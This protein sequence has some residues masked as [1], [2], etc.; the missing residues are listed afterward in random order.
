MTFGHLWSKPGEN[1]LRRFPTFGHLWQNQG[2]TPRRHMAFD[3][4]P[5]AGADLA[6]WQGDFGVNAMSDADNDG[7]S[8]GA[9]FL[10]WQRQL[11]SVAAGG[12]ASAAAPEPAT[13]VLLTLAAAGACLRQHR[14]ASRADLGVGGV[15]GSGFRKTRAIDTEP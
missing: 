5:R 9:D 10:A 4:A 7:D 2:K 3:G 15:R 12:Q 13:W 1:A 6:Q 11:G 14:S 8:D